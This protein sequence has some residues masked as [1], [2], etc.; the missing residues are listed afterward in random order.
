[1]VILRK[2]IMNKRNIIINVILLFLFLFTWTASADDSVCARVK[3]E[4]RQEMTLERQAFDAHMRIN[5]G[6]SHITLENVGIDVRFSDEDGA[7]VLASSDP[8]NTDAL[9]FIRI[10]SLDNIAN[11]DGSGTVQPES[12]ADIHWLIIPAPGASNGLEQG[13]LYYVG[14]TLSYT[15]GGEEHITEV[16]P[17]YIFVKPM[18]ELMLDYFLPSDVYGDDAFTP[19]IEPAIPFN[20]GVRVRNNGS[21]VA[22]S[23]KID[24]AQP[25]IVEN[26]QGLLINFLIEGTE[27][28]G[29]E[30]SPSL[31]ADFGDIDPNSAGVARWI[32]TCSLSGQFI[33]FTAE[34]SHSDELGGELTSLLEEVNTHFLV[35]DVLVDLPGRDMV[36]DFLARDGGVLKVYESNSVDTSVVDQSASA[37]LTLANQFGTEFQY[38]LS[39]PVTAGFMYV[40]LSDPHG[41]T[42]ALKEVIRSDGK[43]IILENSWLSKTRNEDHSWQHFVNIF[44]VNTT[45]SYTLLFGDPNSGSMAPVLQFIPNRQRLEEEQLS[46][47]V[48]ASNPDGTIPALSAEPLP[49]GATFVDQ[50]DGTAIFD[51]TPEIGQAGIYDVI[52]TASGYELS[53]SRDATLSIFSPLD[54][55]GDGLPNTLEDTMC[56]DPDNADSDNDGLKDGVE[57]ANQNGIVDLGETDP[58]DE[59][60]DN[61]GF[62]DGA[63]VQAGTDPLDPD[64]FPQEQVVV[65]L[66]PGFNLLAIPADV[67]TSPNLWAD[68]I[69][70]IG[71][72]TQIEKVLVYD[73]TT[74]VFITFIPGE[75]PAQ[76][77][78]LSGG[79]ALI[80]YAKTEKIVTFSD[81]I[82]S[83]PVLQAGFNLIGISCP[84]TGYSAFDILSDYGSET[85]SSIQRNAT[86]KGIFETAAFGPDNSPV[87]ID[88]PIIPGE[89]Y[90]VIM[91]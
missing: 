27:V 60:S 82:C 50:G 7:S 14:A 26:E 21:G 86:E 9:F 31:L 58:C 74:G 63:E 73:N 42:K 71:D 46:F 53:S 49:A 4:I 39:S 10:D 36:R 51:W 70:V 76:D 48:E 18:P 29:G 91:K 40:Q 24:S 67:S 41:G 90:F 68:W 22:R 6:F 62:S 30:I 5:N 52:F 69:P 12:S 16:S 33:E 37:S 28:N 45:D 17:D 84:A 55:D 23:L 85:I 34:W 80:V 59:D 15:I 43:N 20:L 88:F 56:T 65:N 78:T 81:Q 1:M 61:D 79:E 35:R 83:T 25:K 8:N 75:A 47:I 44:D 32:M 77:Y 66:Q 13:T 19:E 3:I 87:G 38:T 11:V 89:G 54:R 57:D 64:S 2:N 72:A